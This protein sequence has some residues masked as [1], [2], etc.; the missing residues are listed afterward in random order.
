MSLGQALLL[1]I[2]QGLTEF[3]PVSS[4]GHLVLTEHLLGIPAGD[5]SFEV[6]VHFGT[7]VA[8]CLYF[9]ARLWDMARNLFGRQGAG[10][11]A[12]E[13]QRLLA[14]IIVGSIPA[15]VIGLL[16]KDE[17]ESLFADA[18][19][20]AAFLIV[21]GLL[22]LAMRLRQKPDGEITWPRAFLIGVAQAVAILPGISR[23][24]ST[25][26]T[27]SLLGVKPATAAEYSFLLSVPAVLGATLLALPDAIAEG[28]FGLSH[29]LGALAAA[30]VGYLALKWVF[31]SIRQGRFILF[32]IYCIIAGVIGVILI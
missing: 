8:V 11:S 18:H 22:L 31:V 20:A 14:L 13:G 28:T 9:R 25:I 29:I 32:G 2:V 26:A 30:I 24:G 7:L 6:A 27:G 12:R 10:L 5:L 19:L 16:F 15:G 4:S 1:G 3:L 17:I 23:S 21:T